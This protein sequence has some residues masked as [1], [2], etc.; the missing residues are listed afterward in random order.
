[1]KVENRTASSTRFSSSVATAAYGQAQKLPSTKT[2]DSIDVSKS[3]S[4]FQKASAALNNVP[5]VRT[6][7][8]AG[9]QRELNEGTYQRD[10]TQVAER[11]IQDYISFP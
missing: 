7:A 10:E 9:I 1:M 11:V 6:D 3:A 4:L 8:I 5:D 2:D